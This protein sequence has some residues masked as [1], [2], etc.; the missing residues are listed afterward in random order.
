MMRQVAVINLQVWRGTKLQDCCLLGDCTDQWALLLIF[1]GPALYQFLQAITF[2]YNRVSA[3]NKPGWIWSD[4]DHEDLWWF[5]F[6]LRSSPPPCEFLF[7]VYY[8][9]T[10]RGVE[11]D[12]GELSK[13]E[14]Q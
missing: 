9:F 2:S 6:A 3:L 13:L 12:N 1:S 11:E 14:E 10:T 7:V 5:H 4:R 8:V